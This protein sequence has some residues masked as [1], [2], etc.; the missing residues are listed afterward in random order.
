MPL[1]VTK[2]ADPRDNAPLAA[3]GATSIVGGVV[4]AMAGAPWWAIV[5]VIALA[6]GFT[7]YSQTQTER[8]DP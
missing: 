3:G 8:F 6:L 5:V 7:L 2:S 4:L 1:P